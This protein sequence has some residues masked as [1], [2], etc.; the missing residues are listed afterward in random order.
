MNASQIGK[1][2]DLLQR[3]KR[4]L[5]KERLELKQ[6]RMRLSARE[7]EFEERA[8]KE[9]SQKILEQQEGGV[10]DELQQV[11]AA[12]LRIEAGNYGMCISCGMDI[13]LERLRTLPWTD[14]CV[15]CAANADPAEQERTPERESMSSAPP[16][17]AFQGIS[18][19]ELAKA[20]LDELRQDQRIELSELDVEAKDGKLIL[21]G[22]VP[23][24]AMRE[25]LLTMVQDFMGLEVTDN[26]RV[27]RIP[28]LREDRNPGVHIAVSSTPAQ[29]VMEGVPVQEDI[30]EAMRNGESVAPPDRMIPESTMS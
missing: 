5:H 24:M 23:S 28:F 18:D 15:V 17:S 12:L 29:T 19:E 14:K 22:I 11:N 1:L 16:V 10:R 8:Q 3:I 27:D 4:E 20:V 26:I 25:M 21:G 9:Q 30:H 7:V 2:R 6:S 13:S